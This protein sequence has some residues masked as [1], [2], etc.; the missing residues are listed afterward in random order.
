MRSMFATK[1]DIK[2][3]DERIDLWMRSLENQ[4]HKG[5]QQIMATMSD[6]Q[7]ALTQ[8]QTVEGGVILL[9]QTL[10]ADLQNAL[11]TGDASLAQTLVTQIQA[12]TQK[13]ADAIAANT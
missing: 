13:M 6:I 12:N 2:R 7:V 8:E 10:S 5:L 4:L 9:L 3:L 11:N 1:E